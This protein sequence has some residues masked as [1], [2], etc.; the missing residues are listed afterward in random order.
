MIE[1]YRTEP[2]NYR[3]VL[4]TIV[5]SMADYLVKNDIKSQILGISGGIDSTLSA[6]ICKLVYERTNIPLIGVS[7][8]C[9]TNEKDEITSAEL[10]GREF[11]NEF[12]EINIEELFIN[13]EK[14]FN[15][16]G[17]TSTKV[18]Q[19]NIKARIRGSF[20]HNLASICNGIVIDTDNLTEHFLG[21]WTIAGGDE[22]EL[23][24]IGALWKHEVYA[25]ARYIK[26]NVFKD[27]KALENSIAL[28]PTDGNGVAAGG[29]LAQIAPGKTYDDVDDILYHWVGL[30]S[31]IKE[32]VTN[33]DFDCGIFRS[34]C[35][36]YGKDTVKGVIMRSIKSEFKRR[37]RPF[38]I[39]IRRGY[40]CEK[41]GGI[42]V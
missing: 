1:T 29:D 3:K 18:S 7:L 33:G 5:S 34:L 39:D 26:E 13:T 30:D 27:S 36:K 38:V 25:M 37:Q 21:F 35:E 23:N 11:C 42:I 16:F 14:V 9:A 15:S 24:P 41:N 22:G 2:L 4:D 6:A 32:S 40:V 8:P 12:K 31:R 10:T 19:G 28:N 20:L 17:L